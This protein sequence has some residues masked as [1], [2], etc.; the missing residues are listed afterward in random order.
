VT[1]AAIR[2]DHDFLNNFAAFSTWVVCVLLL[3]FAGLSGAKKSVG[4]GAIRV[5]LA[6]PFQDKTS[7]GR[8]EE[9]SFED[10]GQ[11]DYTFA[12]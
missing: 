7:Q 9:S 10:E 5:R 12:G 6:A 3:A 8:K 4:P 11:A 1:G 2:A